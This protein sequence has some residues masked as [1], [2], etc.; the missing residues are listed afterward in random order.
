MRRDIKARPDAA[1]DDI[2]ALRKDVAALELRAEQIEQA[3][4]HEMVHAM[5]PVG[6][7]SA[8]SAIRHN[9]LLLLA[10]RNE[11]EPER[12]IEVA[13]AH[14]RDPTTDR[15]EARACA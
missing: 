6:T 8:E 15:G 4:L 12:L 2:A 5:E 7:V 13:L 14:A 9:I 10:G 1:Q 3:M 11:T